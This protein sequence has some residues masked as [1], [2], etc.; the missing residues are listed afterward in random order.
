MRLRYLCGYH[1]DDNLAIEL[2]FS[3]SQLTRSQKILF[4]MVTF[5]TR[6][7]VW[8]IPCVPYNKFSYIL[9]YSFRVV[10]TSCGYLQATPSAHQRLTTTVELTQLKVDISDTYTSCW[11]LNVNSYWLAA[12]RVGEATPSNSFAIETW[13]FAELHYLIVYF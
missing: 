12:C 10:D 3:I 6:S 8:C 5:D 11:P 4:I 2:N 1:I 13:L 7:V 9:H